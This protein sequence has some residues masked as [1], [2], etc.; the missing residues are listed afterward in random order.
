MGYPVGIGGSRPYSL[1]DSRGRISSAGSC[2]DRSVDLN[3]L[4]NASKAEAVLELHD[5]GDGKPVLELMETSGVKADHESRDQDHVEPDRELNKEGV[6]KEKILSLTLHQCA[7]DG[8]EYN[9]RLLLDRLAPRVKIKKVNQLDKDDLTPLHYAARNNFLPIV[10]LLVDNGADVNAV[11]GEDNVTP[12]HHAA[13]FGGEKK[14]KDSPTIHHDDDEAGLRDIPLLAQYE[15]EFGQKAESVVNY[16]IAKGADINAE[17]KYLQTPLHF[18]AMRG[19]ESACRDLL[20]HKDVKLEAKD[21]QK[22]TPL[23]VAAIYN[24]VETARLLIEAG[25]NLHCALVNVPRK[26]NVYPLHLAA[27]T[28]D[29]RV[30]KLLVEN[31]AKID[32]INDEAATPLHKAAALNRTEVVDYLLLR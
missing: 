21:M 27:M 25:A 17:D 22:Y 16:L 20:G 9:I 30:V 26:R 14:K 24:Q 12:L 4:E 28:G 29:I 15:E 8:H 10:R 7:R 13:R 32:V 23:H 5:A 1:A 2:N 19:N 3:F 6:D 18:A 11:G 31:G